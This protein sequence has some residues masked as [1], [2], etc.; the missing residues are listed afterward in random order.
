MGH[1]ICHHLTM[2]NHHCGNI[3]L[4]TQSAFNRQIQGLSFDAW[5]AVEIILSQKHLCCKKGEAKKVQVTKRLKG[6]KSL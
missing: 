5:Y 1:N 2:N 3:F 4:L 6:V